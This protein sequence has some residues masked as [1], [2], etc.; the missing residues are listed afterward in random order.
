MS[1][2]TEISQ[3]FVN[4]FNGKLGVGSIPIDLGYISYVQHTKSS[5]KKQVMYNL[6]NKD[7]L[8]AINSGKAVQQGDTV[9]CNGPINVRIKKD[10]AWIVIDLYKKNH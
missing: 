7:V 8:N 5:K 10:I 4:L 1:N 6:S 3:E 2:K 9:L